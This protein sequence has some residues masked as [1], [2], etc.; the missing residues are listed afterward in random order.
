MAKTRKQPLWRTQKPLTHEKTIMWKKCGHR[1]F[2][3]PQRTFPICTKRT[4]KINRA[5]VRAAYIRARQYKH[6]SIAN[7]AK[8]LFYKSYKV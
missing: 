5:G 1:C 2:L 7:R 4:C 6:K 3:G 8:R